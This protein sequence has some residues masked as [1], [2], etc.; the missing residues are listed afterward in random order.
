MI[1]PE[2]CPDDGLQ[3]QLP[4]HVTAV[5]SAYFPATQ[6]SQTVLT[7]DKAL[8]LPAGQSM[9]ETTSDESG[10]DAQH[11]GWMVTRKR[12]PILNTVPDREEP[13]KP[14]KDARRGRCHPLNFLRMTPLPRK[15]NTEY[16][17]QNTE[18]RF[19]QPLYQ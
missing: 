16:R 6:L 3:A 10:K 19:S 5:P 11:A 14:R 15:Q 4:K 7:P 17:I 13:G 1:V 12:V 9:P 2:L 18:Y 8:Y